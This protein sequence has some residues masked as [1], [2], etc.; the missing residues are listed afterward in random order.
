M[1]HGTGRPKA[2]HLAFKER[3]L[4]PQVPVLP[5]RFFRIVF[6]RHTGSF[7]ERVLPAIGFGQPWALSI[8]PWHTP[9]PDWC[10]HS[11]PTAGSLFLTDPSARIPAS[12]LFRTNWDS[13]SSPFLPKAI[14][15]TVSSPSLLLC[16][17]GRPSEAECVTQNG[18]GP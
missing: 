11:R 9:C 17:H 16:C 13:Q 7:R 4:L 8:M 10:L 15:D 12:S 1:D 6:R 3:D 2:G 18:G 5:R 14:P